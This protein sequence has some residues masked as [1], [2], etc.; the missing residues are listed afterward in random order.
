MKEENK[1][2]EK[3]NITAMDRNIKINIRETP[4]GNVT[5]KGITEPKNV[6]KI[7]T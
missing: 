5:Q 7:N 4:G 6:M 3:K 1:E 2:K